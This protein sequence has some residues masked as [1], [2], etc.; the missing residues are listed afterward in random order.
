MGI[1]K[2]FLIALKD[3]KLIFRDKSALVLMLLAPF[4]LTLGMGAITGRFSGSAST[5]VSDI[6]VW[7]VNQ[8]EGQLGHTLVEVFQSQELEKLLEPS[9]SDDLAAASAS[10]DANQVAGVIYI[11]KGFS[12]S[13]IPNPGESAGLVQVEFYANPTQPTSTGILRAIL[14]GFLNQVEVGRISAELTVRQ[15]LEE[16]LISPAQAGAVGA[17]IGQKV[18]EAPPSA[19]IKLRN[20]TASGEVIQFDIL[21]YMAPGM[22]MMFL[23]FTVTYGARSLLLESRSWTLPRLLISPTPASFVLGGKVV[24][25]LMTALA[26]LAIL[27]G[28]TSLLFRLAWGDAL[29]VVCLIL[30]AAV[31]ASGW[32]MLFA[33]ILKTPGQIAVT[34]SAVML[35]F[36]ILGGSFFD[37]SLLPGW[38]RVIN[39]ITPNAWALDGFLVLARG[40]RLANIS[41]NI[42]ALLV[43]GVVLFLVASFLIQRRGLAS[44]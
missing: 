13:I 36:G 19:S 6:P 28:G 25:I 17:E 35:L 16:G 18:G 31:A 12:Q 22:A 8:D 33:A 1:R 42:L 21:S 44:K 20:V 37:L 30:A 32:G 27:I 43:M 39:K 14:D 11:P 29:G 40:G 10:V 41:T 26:Q 7:L 34:G 4:L 5:G 38:V 15:L 24:G 2:L 23:M 3:L 9:L